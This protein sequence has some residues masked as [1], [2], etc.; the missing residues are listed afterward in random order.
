MIAT[1]QLLLHRPI[2]QHVWARTTFLEVR[3]AA[4]FLPGRVAVAFLPVA[5][6]PGFFAEG[7]F[8]GCWSPSTN[9]APRAFSGPPR[10]QPRLPRL[11]TFQPVCVAGARPSEH[12]APVQVN[13]ED[14]GYRRDLPAA[15][16]VVR[17]PHPGCSIQHHDPPSGGPARSRPQ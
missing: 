6:V 5:F 12:R 16:F 17:Q 4:V 14:R 15:A 11:S 8:V 10:C 9:L 1:T 3:F 13:Q 2:D 7:F